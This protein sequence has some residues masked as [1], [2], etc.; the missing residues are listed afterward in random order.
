[1]N[2]VKTPTPSDIKSNPK[3]FKITP[4]DAN[5]TARQ[6]DDVD[7][8]IV[9]GGFAMADHVNIKDSIYKEPLN[10]TNK[11]YFNVIVAT[12][13][14]KNKQA[15]KDVIKA[16]QTKA[17][18]NQIKKSYGELEQPAWDIKF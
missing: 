14:N 10:K 7:A 15:Y 16:Y 13:K 5:Q 6:L 11:Q 18:K 2:N 1:M 3:N 8:A 12:K 9:N 4:I 17:V